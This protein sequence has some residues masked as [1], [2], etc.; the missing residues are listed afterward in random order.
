M[1]ESSVLVGSDVASAGVDVAVPEAKLPT[2]LAHVSNDAKGH[3]VLADG[4]PALKPKRVL[5]E[6]IG[7]Y[8]AALAYALH[9]AGLCIAV[10]NPRTARDF[11]RTLQRLAKTDRIDADTLA[12]LVDV[13]ARR[14][15]AERFTWPL[16]ELEQ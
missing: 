6:A 11:A 13:L 3:T 7:G 14:P 2:A 15:D 5:M 12:E 9:A 16:M 1:S 4:L 8:E 10:I